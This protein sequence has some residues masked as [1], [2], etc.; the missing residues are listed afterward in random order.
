M[1][2]GNVGRGELILPYL[3]YSGFDLTVLL[4][5]FRYYLRRSTSKSGQCGVVLGVFRSVD[6][7]KLYVTYPFFLCILVNL[8]AF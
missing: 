7:S 4:F 3:W 1:F 2:E 8:P 5:R 6:N